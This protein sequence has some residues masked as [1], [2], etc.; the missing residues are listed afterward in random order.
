MAIASST[1]GQTLFTVS[2]EHL[3]LRKELKDGGH[4]LYRNS[5]P[6]P[7]LGLPAL[8][9]QDRNREDNNGRTEVPPRPI[10]FFTAYTN[11]KRPLLA[12]QGTG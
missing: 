9:R 5:R 8:R 12:N 10:C 1:A 11:F 7:G 4:V 3:R 6:A 2:A